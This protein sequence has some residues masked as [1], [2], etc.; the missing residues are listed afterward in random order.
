MLRQGLGL[1]VPGLQPEALV[2]EA[3]L[4]QPLVGHLDSGERP[5]STE[6]DQGWV[7]ERR[8]SEAEQRD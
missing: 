3:D 4:V 5:A 6:E 7:V 1:A 8:D 2:E